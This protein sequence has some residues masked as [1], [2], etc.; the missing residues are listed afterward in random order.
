MGM[1]KTSDK[2]YDKTI[3]KDNDIFSYKITIKY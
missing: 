3:D 1:D 2:S